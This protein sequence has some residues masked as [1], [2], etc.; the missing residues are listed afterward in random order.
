MA[1]KGFK[2][3]G[4]STRKGKMT[5]NQREKSQKLKAL[6]GAGILLV[7]GGLGIYS[8]INNSGE[9]QNNGSAYVST[10]DNKRDVKLYDE[11]GEV[12][13]IFLGNDEIINPVI[14]IESG[15]DELERNQ[16]Y[17]RDD[18]GNIV[19]GYMDTSDILQKNI[20]EIKGFFDEE[21]DVN[22]GIVSGPNGVFAR[23]NKIVD[24]N[25]DDAELLPQG[26]YILCGIPETSK[27]NAYTWRKIVYFKDGEN[28][29]IAYMVDEYL[30]DI[31]DLEQYRKLE[32]TYDFLNV[33]QS[34]TKDVDNKK[35]KLEQGDFVYVVPNIK[36]KVDEKND[37]IFVAY[38]NRE[39][40]EIEFGWIAGA[41]REYDKVYV[42]EVN[43]SEETTIVDTRVEM[44]VDTGSV[45]SVDLKVRQEPGLDAK[46]KE[47]LQN[48]T[49]VYVMQSSFENIEEVDGFKWIKIF[50]ENGD[51]GYVALEYLKD[52]EISQEPE[53]NNPQDTRIEMIVDTSSVGYVNLKLREAPGTDAKI[54]M[55]LQDGTRVY[56][57]QRFIDEAN[58]SE[59]IDGHKWIQ[60]IAED[61][62][63]GTVAY[64]YIAERENDEEKFDLNTVEYRNVDVFSEG[65]VEGVL[66]VDVSP[67][68]VSIGQFKELLKQDTQIPGGK[69]GN[70]IQGVMINIGGTGYGVNSGFCIVGKGQKTDAESIEIRKKETR[71]FITMCEEKGIPYGT[72][73][74]S[75]AINEAETKAE[76]DYILDVFGELGELKYNVFGIAVDIEEVKGRMGKFAN[77][78]QENK[79]ELT[80]LKQK[81]MQELRERTGQKVII[82]SDRNALDYIIDY[83][84]LTAE[85]RN[86]IWLVDCSKTHSDSLREMGM[87]DDIGMRQVALDV[88][89]DGIPIDINYMSLELYKRAIEQCGFNDIK[90]IEV[91]NDIER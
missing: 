38:I 84:Q 85:N 42:E 58:Q 53:L 67:T 70:K 50:L 54:K 66:V 60:I 15:N 31:E 37:W 64:D 72:Y 80:D 20:T 46:I 69:Y 25:T 7:G 41:D 12:V 36:G 43:E 44:I 52:K 47:K 8:I 86:D 90:Y 78:S 28:V 40:D 5:N 81:M 33:R 39:T 3:T 49:R 87:I 48:G 74:Y 89:L 32:V 18:D 22:I 59:E 21:E 16:V 35:Y 82:Y 73:Y 13:D 71:A 1:R 23:Q 83:R 11:D 61:G 55:N 29:E 27:D 4:K 77:Q 6:V 30:L 63:T 19:K 51:S 17:V 57:T 68:Y 76:I 65:K 45:G 62:T 9:T 88:S 24:T 14:S 10:V 2:I 91:E 79:S 34:P 26:T 56:T 75:Q